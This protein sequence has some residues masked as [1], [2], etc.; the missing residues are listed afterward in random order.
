MLSDEFDLVSETVE[1]MEQCAL[2]IV[3]LRELNA[4]LLGALKSVIYWKDEVSRPFEY[5]D[6]M[7][8]KVQAAI[9]AAEEISDAPAS[10]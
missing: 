7:I 1:T 3:R 4:Q 8:E 6:T 5:Y 2:E 9:H 10:R